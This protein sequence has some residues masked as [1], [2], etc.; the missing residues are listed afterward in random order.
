[1]KL[2]LHDMILFSATA[3]VISPNGT[4]LGNGADVLDVQTWELDLG[5]D[6]TMRLAFT[7][8]SP[9]LPLVR[10][11]KRESLTSSDARNVKR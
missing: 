10:H 2:L 6:T 5:Q 9:R 1:M 11:I 8:G 4:H 7:L 3:Y